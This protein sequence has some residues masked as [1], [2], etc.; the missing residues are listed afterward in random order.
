MHE[1]ENEMKATTFGVLKLLK[2]AFTSPTMYIIILLIGNAYM[3]YDGNNTDRNEAR[4]EG[5]QM[6][7]AQILNTLVNDLS[8][9][10]ETQIGYPDKDGNILKIPLVVKQEDKK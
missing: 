7:S 8:T 3:T 4:L 9:K 2:D 1:E 6:A 10:G 5:A